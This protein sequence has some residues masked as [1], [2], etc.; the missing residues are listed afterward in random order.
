MDRK[1]SKCF[2]SSMVHDIMIRISLST[3]YFFSLSLDRKFAALH[4][5]PRID[6]CV[7][8]SLSCPCLCVVHSPGFVIYIFNFCRPNRKTLRF[9]GGRGKRFKLIR[10]TCTRDNRDVRGFDFSV[11]QKKDSNTC[12]RFE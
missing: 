9:I 10:L 11:T 2:L 1:K 4:P 6:V 7:R 5:D 3:N 12:L 8:Y